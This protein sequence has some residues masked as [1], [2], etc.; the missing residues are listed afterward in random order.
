MAKL[1]IKVSL[2]ILYRNK[3]FAF[4]NVLGLA[5]GISVTIIAYLI[6]LND[7]SYDRFHKDNDRIYRVVSQIGAEPN[8]LFTSGVPIPLGDAIRNQVP[9]V[10]EVAPFFTTNDLTVS[11]PKKDQT[12]SYIHQKGIIFAGPSYFNIFSYK[13]LAGTPVAALTEPYKVV[14][15][16]HAAE[17]YYPDIPLNGVLGQKLILRDSLLT[18]V[19]GIVDDQKENTDLT[20]NVFVSRATVQTA[21]LRS[22]LSS[23]WSV[24]IGYSQLFVKL[25]KGYALTNIRQSLEQIYYQHSAGAQNASVHQCPYR[26]QPLADMHFDTRFGTYF[27]NRIANKTT[28]YGLLSGAIL[29]LLLA[30]INF[31]NLSTAHA[32]DRAKEIA[33]KKTLGSSRKR[34]VYQFL[35]ETFILALAAGVLSILFVPILL[36]ALADLIPPGVGFN[37]FKSPSVLLVLL[38]IIIILTLISGMYPSWVL[39]SF[40]PARILKKHTGTTG[41]G[42]GLWFRK[43]LILVQ[44]IISQVFVTSVLFVGL[45]LRYAMNKDLGFRKDAIVYFEIS[46]RDTVVAKKEALFNRLTSIPGIERVSLSNEPVSTRGSWSG[47]VKYSNG[48]SEIEAT[49]QQIFAD[50]N[51]LPLFDIPILAGRNIQGDSA[52]KECVINIACCQQLGFRNAKQAIGKMLNYDDKRIQIVGV[53]A[54]FYQ[55]SLYEPIKPL[56]LASDLNNQKVFNIALSRT[57]GQLTGD[58]LKSSIDKIAES[59]KQ[60]Y[61]KDYFTYDFQS[62]TIAQYY[63]ADMRLSEL[64]KYLAVLTLFVSSMGLLGLVIYSTN[65]RKKEISIRKVLGASIG[66]IVR[67]FLIEFLLLLL[68]AFA[69]SIPFSYFFVHH[70]LNNFAYRISLSW[71]IFAMSGIISGVVALITV[72]AQAVKSAIISP[73]ILLRAE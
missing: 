35:T 32:A 1:D 2:R 67:L 59:F 73:S 49:V 4:I 17:Y 56:M 55:E 14:L 16:K 57:P 36:W 25:A 28:L 41:G 46:N 24:T 53:M 3:I 11:I 37:P 19:S 72:A 44:F 68:L 63:K 42:T 26:L 31:V 62:D 51:F 6:L 8:L 38:L 70:W 18:T 27:G 66:Q 39:S 71:W 7:F 12:H 33:I 10:E 61:P 58:Q 15:T 13:W 64:L 54:N 40:K 69:V 30:C 21:R 48:I 22:P 45:Q 60:I 65:N 20:F 23:N 47:L 50:T 29:L 52:L 9:G 5:V 34:L 43:S